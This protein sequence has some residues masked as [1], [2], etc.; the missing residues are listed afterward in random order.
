MIGVVRAA[1]INSVGGFDQQQHPRKFSSIIVSWGD[2]GKLAKRSTHPK[3]A[4]TLSN[5]EFLLRKTMEGM[6]Q[7]PK[8]TEMG[9]EI[10]NGDQMHLG[11][12]G[13]NIPKEWAL[14][15]YRGEHGAD[16]EV[17]DDA[18]TLEFDLDEEEVIQECRLLAIVAYYSRK[19]Y[20]PQALFSDMTVAWGVEW[21]AS[22]EKSRDYNFRLEFSTEAE[23]WRI[24]NGGPWRHK[25][26]AL[27]N[28][29]FDGLTRPSEV[30]IASIG[31]WIRFY[32]LPP[33]MMKE[34]CA[35]VLGNQLGKYVSMDAK[36]PGY[37]RVRV[38]FP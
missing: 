29:H 21:L 26:D 34:S 1:T 18:D 20:N 10:A 4:R 12:V 8:L 23:K 36:Y 37:L 32:D 24:I 13:M 5:L 38:D 25:G 14:E 15:V 9:A 31:L 17:T 2:Q 33:A 7:T 16:R 27:I 35:K 19:G 3:P 6:S 30:R 22:L 28:V 11:F